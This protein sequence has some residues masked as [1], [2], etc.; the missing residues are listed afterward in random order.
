M[1]MSATETVRL[2]RYHGAAG[3]DVSGGVAGLGI[4]KD[5]DRQAQH[6][7]RDGPV[8]VDGQPVAG[9][10]RAEELFRILDRLFLGPAV[11]VP[12][13]DGFRRGLAPGTI[14]PILDRLTRAG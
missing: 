11:G 1:S 5:E 10:S 12:V 14:Y 4:P 9:V 13:R 2:W 6:G 3:G 8:H 7:E